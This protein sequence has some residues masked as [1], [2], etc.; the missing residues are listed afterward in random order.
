MGYFPF[1]VDI[2]GKRGLIVGGGTVAL[3]KIRKLL[4][5]GPILK[6]VSPAILPELLEMVQNNEILFRQREF[7]END[8]QDVFF[9]IASCDNPNVNAQVSH[10]CH[11]RGI[12]V[13]VA[14]NKEE[15][16]FLFPALVHQ[17]ALTIGVTTAGASPEVAAAIKNE[18]AASI[19]ANMEEILEYLAA[20][21]LLAKEKICDSKI[22]AQFLK[23][24]ARFCMENGTIFDEKE[25]KQKLAAFIQKTE[26]IFEQQRKLEKSNLKRQ[27]EWD[28]DS[29]LQKQGFGYEGLASADCGEDNQHKKV[30]IAGSVTLVGAGC[31]SYELITLKGLRVIRYAQV[32]IY[33]DLIDKRLLDF[34]AES[35]ECI[36]VGKRSGKH[37][38][39]QNQINNLLLQ[40]A[41]EG[42]RI[43]RLKGGDPFVFG[44]GGEEINFLNSKQIATVYIPGISAAIAVP[45]FARIPVTY[46]EVSRSVHIITG[47]TTAT[48]STLPEHIALLAKLN[49]TLVFLMG[50]ENLAQITQTLIKYG[51]SPNTPAAVIH[52]NFDNTAD[53][54]RGILSDIAE[55]VQQSKI[56]APAVIVVGETVG[57]EL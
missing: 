55:K 50:L 28:S 4:P 11:K 30:R 25:T 13:N 12:L 15:C 20:L 14:D 53:S 31:G 33:D 56:I 34:A 39:N 47:H 7:Q 36:Y 27:R 37:S 16:S 18:V 52:G 38:M 46:R 32:I 45:A 44:R 22:R 24:M 2:E 8:L 57:I 48:D 26:E 35:C 1:F 23:E 3:H 40:K 43:V 41:K 17:G 10:L 29:I 42:K 51:K 49:G 19:P 21:R 54:I 9:V 5:F 6:V